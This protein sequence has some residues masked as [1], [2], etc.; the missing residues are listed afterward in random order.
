MPPQ[1]DE[2]EDR[3]RVKDEEKNCRTDAN[4]RHELGDL[5]LGI[6]ARDVGLPPAA[7]SAALLVVASCRKIVEVG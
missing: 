1:H 3:A 5:A 4:T 6:R 2:A 7:E